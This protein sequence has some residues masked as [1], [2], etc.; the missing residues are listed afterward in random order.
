MEQSKIRNYFKNS[1]SECC[2]LFVGMPV[3][4]WYKVQR[5]QNGIILLA[6]QKGQRNQIYLA[7]FYIWL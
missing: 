4:V 3:C 2:E 1:D 6:M 7:T 5:M